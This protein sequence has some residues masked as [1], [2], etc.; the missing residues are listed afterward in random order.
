M[1]PLDDE[2]RQALSSRAASLDPP[3]DPLAG[4]EARAGRIRRAR[5]ALAA[6]GAALAVAVVA[7]AVPAL[8]TGRSPA[9]HQIGTTPTA[10]VTTG[11]ESWAYRGNAI[12]QGTL[13]AF[14]REWGAKHPGSTLVPLFGQ[15]YEPSAT[16]ELVF[17]AG[18]RV[19]V[20]QSSASGPELLYDEKVDSTD[21]LAFVLPGDEVPRVLAVGSPDST[22]LTLTD[23]A[24]PATS[25]TPLAPGV[26]IGPV[27]ATHGGLIVKG[28]DG[29]GNAFDTEPFDLTKTPANLLSWGVRGRDPVSPD[30]MDL[31]RRFAQA[32]DRPDDA[33][34]YSPLYVDRVDGVSFTVG[35]AWFDGDDKA[36][37]VS[38]AVAS[39]NVPQFFLGPVTP[40]DPWG[41]AFVV[42]GMQT[43]Q[44]LVVVPRPGV[45][46]VSYAPHATG[47]FTA[48]A[49]GRSDLNGIALVQRD[50][51]A[52]DDRLQVL[53]GDG[54]LDHPLYQGPVMPLLC[55]LKECG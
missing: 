32:L 49:S 55:G 37:T 15:V 10:S 51:Q 44:L 5:V 1:T 25:L 54:D 52:S 27:G 41:L 46:Q 2:L 20:I 31:R 17:V 7:V 23:A 47:S 21:V 19:G 48:V 40:T 12:P 28:V 3:A 42:E 9:P 13:D 33:T 53:D 30:T 22:G 36:Y 50:L 35:Q 11:P 6:G 4:I 34:S 38:Y 45:G 43:Y 18:D 29:N 39:D 26:G 24:H 14:Q 16:Q 8:D